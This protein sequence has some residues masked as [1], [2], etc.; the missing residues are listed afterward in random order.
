MNRASFERVDSLLAIKAEYEVAERAST[1]V[2]LPVNVGHLA[3]VL[4]RA[5]AHVI[6]RGNR[7]FEGHLLVLFEQLWLQIKV[8]DIQ[9]TEH[10]ATTSLCTHKTANLSLLDLVYDHFLHALFT[11]EMLTSDQKRKL[12]SEFVTHA[13]VARVLFLIKLSSVCFLSVLKVPLS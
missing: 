5:P 13:N 9:V 7:V 1:L 12:R 8:L 6:H 2:L 3:A 4:D 10:L 11:K